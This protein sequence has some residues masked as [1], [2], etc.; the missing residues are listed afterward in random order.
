MAQPFEDP[1]RTDAADRLMDELRRAYASIVG[2]D[3]PTEQEVAEALRTLGAAGSTVA[4]AL[5][6]AG[7]DEAVRRHLIRALGSLGEAA[8]A[9][10]EEL[11]PAVGDPTI[12]DAGR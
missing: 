6:S 12:E 11:A 4:R 9:F 8:S 1:A 3:G 2:E 7:R 10:L 5:G